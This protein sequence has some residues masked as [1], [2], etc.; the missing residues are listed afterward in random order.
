MYIEK[1][2][3][4]L[5]KF[6]QN[7]KNIKLVFRGQSR[8]WNTIASSAARRMKK[9][10]QTNQS[11]FIKYHKILLKNARENGYTHPDNT[12][13]NIK[14]LKDL[15]LLANIQHMG[16]ATCLTDFTTNFLV[17]LWFATATSINDTDGE[18]FVINLKSNS[19]IKLYKNISDK[20]DDIDKILTCK[21][22]N[23]DGRNIHFWIWKPEG[24]NKRICNQSSIFLFG[25][26]PVTEDHKIP[27]KKE[28]KMNIRRE[29][30]NYFNIDVEYLYP[31]FS[32]FSLDVNSSESPLNYFFS[33]DCFDI[34]ADYLEEKHYK[35][36]IRYLNKIIACKKNEKK[37]C[38][39]RNEQPCYISLWDAYYLKGECLYQSTRIENKIHEDIK[40]TLYETLYETFNDAICCFKELIINK[41]EYSVDSTMY[42]FHIYYDM[43]RYEKQN[44]L[45]DEYNQ[46]VNECEHIVD[47]YYEYAADFNSLVY[48]S[49]IELSIL[50]ENNSKFIR[51]MSK[52]NDSIDLKSGY[53]SFLIKY[54]DGIGKI[55]WNDDD[56]LAKEYIKELSK[57][58][59]TIQKAIP[60]SDEIELG[61]FPVELT[62]KFDDMLYWIKDKTLSSSYLLDLTKKMISFQDIWTEYS[63]CKEIFSSNKGNAK[64]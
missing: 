54:F 23:D 43:L 5:N 27:V 61:K 55:I 63:Y 35:D 33:H 44:S 26:P 6:V 41:T 47:E 31:D 25:L 17:A 32:G 12:N 4:D 52:V 64:T 7:E 34:A 19:N 58:I 29:L 38:S 57:H 14:D 56:T 48:F 1:Y 18:I 40:E 16:G 11:D 15:E 60:N 28:D 10:N 45:N 49:L 13:T 2:I 9:N 59:R 30:K 36:C 22:K 50:T 62:W 21:T 51:L 37:E 8:D 39:R 53:R 42:I 3:E 24:Y 46:I 20:D